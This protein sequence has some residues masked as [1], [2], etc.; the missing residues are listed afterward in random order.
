MADKCDICYEVYNSQLNPPYTC[1]PC[2]H[3]F[4][5]PCIDTWIRDHNNNC[6]TCRLNI[7]NIVQNRDLLELI[8][9]NNSQV[10]SGNN[11]ENEHNLE[12]EPYLMVNPQK[13]NL[14]RKDFIKDKSNMVF[15]VADN[16]LS[17]QEC[18]GKIFINNK[19]INFVSRWEEATSKIISIAEYN[20]KRGMTATYYLL[21]PQKT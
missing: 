5:K 8:E 7:Q 4:C 2:G 9:S 17:M 11:S 16:S 3:V 19:K 20:I 1:Q 12:T 18:D 6:P 14:E 15:Y 10:Q 21:N 13:N